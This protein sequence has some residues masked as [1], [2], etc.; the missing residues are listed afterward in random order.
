MPLIKDKVDVF[1]LAVRSRA[2]INSICQY[3]KDLKKRDIEV[4]ERHVNIIRTSE[5]YFCAF[6][7]D[8][9][10]KKRT[11]TE[12]KIEPFIGL[13]GRKKVILFD[14]NQEA[15]VEDLAILVAKTF[16]PNPNNYEYIGF[17]DKDTN[18]CKVENLFWSE[19]K[20]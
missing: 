9:L 18:N 20:Q 19:T 3:S 17:L 12:E 16:L 15:Q 8:D 14:K 7:E 4:Y 5:G 2:L 6:Y 11:K 13:D 10:K 1:A